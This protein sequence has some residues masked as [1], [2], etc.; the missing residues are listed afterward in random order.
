MPHRH[1]SPFPL[2]ARFFDWSSAESK[3]KQQILEANLEAWVVPHGGKHG[4]KAEAEVMPRW[5]CAAG[6]ATERHS[7][8]PW[9]AKRAE[10][11][12]YPERQR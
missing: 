3:G 9:M 12:P 5:A 10:A 11:N 2:R 7:G 8:G 4:A 1:C 6:F